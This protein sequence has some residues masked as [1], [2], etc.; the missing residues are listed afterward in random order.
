MGTREWLPVGRIYLQ[1]GW[2]PRV[3]GYHP[4]GT[5]ERL[6]L[7]RKDKQRGCWGGHSDVLKWIRANGCPWGR[8]T[9][10]FAAYSGDLEVLQWLRAN[11]CPWDSD[12]CTFA[13]EQGHFSVLEW[14]LSNGCPQTY[15]FAECHCKLVPLYRFAVKGCPYYSRE[16]RIMSRYYL[17]E[18]S[19]RTPAHTTQLT[20][21]L[22]WGKARL[23]VL[24]TSLAPIHVVPSQNGNTAY[25]LF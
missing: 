23:E 24:I 12:T 5:G 14:A 16:R 21:R 3:F 8:R 17:L 19:A 10:A 9:C 11:R 6:P 18:V 22:S 7:G 1:R 20:H 25:N 15:G 2:P 4:V 13:A